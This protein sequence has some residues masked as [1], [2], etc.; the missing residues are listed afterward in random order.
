MLTFFNNKPFNELIEKGHLY[1]AQPPLFKVTKGSKSIYIKNEKDL[2]KYILKSKENGAKKLKKSELEK[3]INEEKQKLKET[4][5][6]KKIQ[7]ETVIEDGLYA[8]VGNKAIVKSDIIN[9][10][11]AILILSNKINIINGLC[12]FFFFY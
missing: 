11:K 7:V 1:L 10:I 3:F 2:E 9:E 12:L 5:I 8:T 6:Q 4:K